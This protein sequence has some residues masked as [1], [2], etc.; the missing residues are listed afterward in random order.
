M[1]PL[2]FLCQFLA[3]LNYLQHLKCGSF[4][5]FT[6]EEI[7]QQSSTLFSPNLA[8]LDLQL[9]PQSHECMQVLVG[10]ISLHSQHL[11]VRLKLMIGFEESDEDSLDLSVPI[12]H[13]AS[14]SQLSLKVILHDELGSSSIQHVL[15]S[16]GGVVESLEL[17]VDK[18][19]LEDM[20]QQS[21]I[22]MPKLKVLDL[23]GRQ[24]KALQVVHSLT[25][26]PGK[27]L[28]D[29]IC[30]LFDLFDNVSC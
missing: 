23:H 6:P 11:N 4:H 1:L 30:F 27:S 21:R 25:P 5:G 2:L 22:Q 26:L 17:S 28:L 12:E 18:I 20:S 29:S 13:L 10:I 24:H 19:N 7:A 15:R 8:F 9:K 14:I 3:T 16:V